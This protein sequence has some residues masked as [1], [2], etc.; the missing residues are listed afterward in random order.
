MSEYNTINFIEHQNRTITANKR[1]KPASVMVWAGVTSTDEKTPLI[2]IEEEVEN[3]QHVYLNM[4]KEQLVPWINATFKESG[5]NLQQDGATP[6]T[7]NLV[8]VW[9]SKNTA[10]FWTKESW[11]PSPDLNLMDFAVWSILDSNACSSYHP[12]VTSIKT[13]LRHC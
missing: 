6:H 7:A 2:F 3:N 11:P 5:I 1:Q 13:K 8:H 9:C 12:S 10:G 4:L